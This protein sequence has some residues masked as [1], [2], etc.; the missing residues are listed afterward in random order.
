VPQAKWSWCDARSKFPHRL[1]EAQLQGDWLR[2][3]HPCRLDEFFRSPKLVFG[4]YDFSAS[5][6][7]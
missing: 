7:L 4:I 5:F 6:P 3:N 1:Q 2:G